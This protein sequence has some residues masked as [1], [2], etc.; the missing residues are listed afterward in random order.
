MDNDLIGPSGKLKA[1]PASPIKLPLIFAFWLWVT[2]SIPAYAAP[3]VSERYG[4]VYY[5]VENGSTRLASHLFAPRITAFR[6][7]RKPIDGP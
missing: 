6:L 1:D 3:S 7:E 2:L 4:N 5:S